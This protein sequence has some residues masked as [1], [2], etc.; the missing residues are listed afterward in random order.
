MALTIS[1]IPVERIEAEAPKVDL[2]KGVVAVLR[3]LWTLVLAVPY[4]VAWVI[5]KVCLGVV[6]LGTAAAVGW[7][8]GMQARRPEGDVER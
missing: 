3:L 6:M 4:A 1:G 5:G 2:R 7:R 8:D